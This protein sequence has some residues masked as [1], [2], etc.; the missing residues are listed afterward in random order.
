MMRKQLKIEPEKFQ[1]QYK[2][3]KIFRVRGQY[4]DYNYIY[5]YFL[6]FINDSPQK[7][8]KSNKKNLICISD[9][10]TISDNMTNRVLQSVNNYT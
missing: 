3:H 1:P 7:P 9:G 8:H 10:N 4:Y 6:V 5:W 2:V